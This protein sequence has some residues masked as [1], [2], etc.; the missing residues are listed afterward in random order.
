ME[1]K[2]RECSLIQFMCA[3]KGNW[4]NSVFIECVTCT[5]NNQA[6]CFGYLLTADSDGRPLIVSADSMHK[7]TGH[8][9]DKFECQAILSR[10]QFETIFAHWLEW[11]VESP[12][13]CALYQAA[14]KMCCDGNSNR[15]R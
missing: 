10:T 6:K 3:V 15:F 7:A 4:R 9:P 2:S 14:G 8:Y 13:T 5:Q 1:L 12:N 11:N